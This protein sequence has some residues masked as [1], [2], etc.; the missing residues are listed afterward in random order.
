MLS[1]VILFFT[2]I[3]QEHF[4]LCLNKIIGIDFCF[5]CGIGRSI[6]STLNGEF[7]KSFQ[8]HFFG[9]PATIILI[10]RIYNLSITKN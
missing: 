7:L 10:N 6:S 4:S 2:N 1:L 8:F 9:I 3:N 5:G